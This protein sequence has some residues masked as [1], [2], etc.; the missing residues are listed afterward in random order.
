VNGI[1]IESFIMHWDIENSMILNKIVQSNDNIGIDLVFIGLIK[2]IKI[3]GK[4]SK[5]A[6]HRIERVLPNP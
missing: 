2:L 4:F 3:P 5:M 6:V 1:I